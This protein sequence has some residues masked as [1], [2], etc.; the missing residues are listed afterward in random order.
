MTKGGV[1]GNVVVES[2]GGGGERRVSM[3]W[4]SGQLQLKQ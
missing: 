2:K 3:V 4:I 1:R